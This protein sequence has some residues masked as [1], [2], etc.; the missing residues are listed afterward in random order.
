M[1]ESFPMLLRL[2]A[3]IAASSGFIALRAG[4]TSLQRPSPGRPSVLQKVCLSVDMQTVPLSR[5][6]QAAP[7]CAQDVSEPVAATGAIQEDT[8][9]HVP[10]PPQQTAAPLPVPANIV[11]DLDWVPLADPAELLAPANLYETRQ[12]GVEMQGLLLDEDELAAH[13][14]LLPAQLP[15][16]DYRIL[17]DRGGVGWLWLR[18]LAS[19]DGESTVEKPLLEKPAEDGVWTTSLG[20]QWVRFIPIPATAPVLAKR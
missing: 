2:A 8:E 19:A 14:R 20:T 18:P 7:V 10:L 15:C 17:D 12:V 16:G 9:E 6:W 11:V 1:T 4:D 5:A 13:I 3:L